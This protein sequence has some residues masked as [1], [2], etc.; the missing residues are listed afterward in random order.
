MRSFASFEMTR[1]QLTTTSKK[2]R[3]NNFNCKQIYFNFI[4]TNSLR[5]RS[6]QVNNNNKKTIAP[7]TTPTIAIKLHI[8]QQHLIGR[9][10]CPQSRL[11]YD[12]A[13][14]QFHAQLS[15]RC[16]VNEF[17]SISKVD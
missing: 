3:E 15:E 16:V 2:T 10:Q 9:T 5:F 6:F 17:K 14:P 4:S 11:R 13:Q 12:V 8:L 7:V 1:Q